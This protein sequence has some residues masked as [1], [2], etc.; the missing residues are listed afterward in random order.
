MGKYSIMISKSAE[1][2][3][4]YI[5][6]SG[7]KAD[8]EKVSV[9]F[10]EISEHPR[11]GTGK[12]EQLK[13]YDREVWSRKLNKKD[14]FIYEIYEGEVLVIVIQSLGHYDDK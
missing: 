1:K 9:F 8:I 14:R 6:R 12:P 7:K 13:Y 3:L 10:K 2:D 11:T 5:K 4:S